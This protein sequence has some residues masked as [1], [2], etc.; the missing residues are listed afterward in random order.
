[1]INDVFSD[2]EKKPQKQKKTYIGFACMNFVDKI[3]NKDQRRFQRLAKYSFD[4]KLPL[5]R[6]ILNELQRTDIEPKI[7]REPETGQKILYG[8]KD[9]VDKF[10]H[11][12]GTNLDVHLENVCKNNQA[13]LIVYDEI[14]QFTAEEFVEDKDK[15]D[16]IM[17]IKVFYRDSNSFGLS[18][19]ILNEE[20]FNNLARFRNTVEGKVMSA[21]KQAIKNYTPTIQKSDTQKDSKEDNSFF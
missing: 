13:V 16:L 9:A 15:N 5:A 4:M 8:N 1:M 7:L 21:V 18:Y 2:Q 12:L 11:K 3:K 14:D 20:K 19:L 17:A 6:Q 10:H